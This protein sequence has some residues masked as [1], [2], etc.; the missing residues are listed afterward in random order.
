MILDEIALQ[1]FGLYAGRQTM[2]LTPPSSSKP[3]VLIG[4][5]NGG[6]K[7][8][9][10]DALQL[11]L[12]GP[13]ARIS[14]RGSVAYPEYLSRCVHRGASDQAAAVEIAFRHTLEGQEDHYR[15]QRSWR[16]TE[17]GCKE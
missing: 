17:G 12:Y 7:T 16:V 6:G 14:N 3:V 1:N 10:L 4:G 8:T 11:C 2:V 5:L 13:H 9:L 15:L